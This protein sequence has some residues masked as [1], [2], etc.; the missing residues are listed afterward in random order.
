[1]GLLTDRREEERV[2][3]LSGREEEKDGEKRRQEKKVADGRAEMCEHFYS[4]AERNHGR[5]TGLS[6]CMCT[7]RVWVQRVSSRGHEMQI[8]QALYLM[9]V[10]EILQIRTCNQGH[11]PVRFNQETNQGKQRK[12]DI[13]HQPI[14]YQR[15]RC[16]LLS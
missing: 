9:Y 6:G 12:K 13:K 10:L 7:V 15:F 16:T 4:K 11:K 14:T 1:M 3:Q 2:Q 5:M 8:S